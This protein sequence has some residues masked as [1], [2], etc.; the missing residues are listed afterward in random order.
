MRKYVALLL[1]AFLLA[2]LLAASGCGKKETPPASESTT[3]STPA[4]GQQQPADKPADQ[5]NQQAAQA[6]DK[7]ASDK[8]AEDKAKDTAKTEAPKQAAPEKTPFEAYLDTLP[9]KFNPNNA[10]GVSCVYQFNITDGHPGKYWVKINDGKCTV[11]K[12]A[13][14]SPNITIN[15]GEQLWLDIAANKVNGTMAF[16]S[17]KFTAQGDTDYLS[18]MKKYFSK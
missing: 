12:G 17:K 15:V 16:L 5:A 13:Q 10:Q 4:T 8:P 1:S 9:G 6:T 2:S 14:P 7:P 11:G 3:Q 18:N